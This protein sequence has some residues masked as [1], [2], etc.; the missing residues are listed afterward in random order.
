MANFFNYKIVGSRSADKSEELRLTRDFLDMLVLRARG[1]Q[2]TRTLAEHSDGISDRSGT[3]TSEVSCTETSERSCTGSTGDPC[4]KAGLDVDENL[5]KLSLL[6]AEESLRKLSLLEP[7]ESL[8]KLNLLEPEEILRKLSLL[9]PEE[10]LRKLSIIE[11]TEEDLPSTQKSKVGIL[12]AIL[13][14]IKMSVH[15]LRHSRGCLNGH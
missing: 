4:E 8:R 2:G 5:R 10:S 11:D 13:Y 15:H 14:T 6:E 3:G 1:G 12:A 9:E 7:E